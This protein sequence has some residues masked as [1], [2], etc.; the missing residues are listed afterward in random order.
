[1]GSVQAVQSRHPLQHRSH[2]YNYAYHIVAYKYGS[3]LIKNHETV[4][5]IISEGLDLWD[6]ML[7]NLAHNQAFN[8]FKM[9]G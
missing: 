3:Y 6:Q 8:W 4:L 1:M 7:C 5:F 9:L 2:D